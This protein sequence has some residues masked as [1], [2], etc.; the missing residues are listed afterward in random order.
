MARV[1]EI[2]LLLL[3]TQSIYRMAAT[4][5]PEQKTSFH[6]SLNKISLAVSVMESQDILISCVSIWISETVITALLIWDAIKK[7]FVKLVFWG[8]SKL[9]LLP[10]IFYEIWLFDYIYNTYAIHFD[11]IFK[12]II[13]PPVLLFFIYLIVQRF[14]SYD[15]LPNNEQRM[16]DFVY[17][18]L[19]S[20]VFNGIMTFQV[21][22][23]LTTISLST[24]ISK[25]ENVVYIYIVLFG[26]YEIMYRLDLIKQQ[27]KLLRNHFKQRANYRR[28]IK[29][30][31]ESRRANP[32]GE[33]VTGLAQDREDISYFTTPIPATIA[34]NS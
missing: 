25:E 12:V 13:F 26:L 21:L 6:V 16:R 2:F 19:T 7:G 18:T 20:L 30:K 8:S 15:E 3:L 32:D 31:R 1:R 10:S 24:G 11:W 9:M 23:T 33:L 28:K 27:F 34:N 4:V 17:Y 14:I 5:F 22:C 29:R